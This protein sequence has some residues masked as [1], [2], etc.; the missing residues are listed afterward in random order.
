MNFWEAQRKARGRTTLYLF[1]FVLLTLAVAV[2]IEYAV[3]FLY[4]E[5]EAPSMSYMGPLFLIVTFV[6]A[7]FYYLTYRSQGGSFVAESLGGKRVSPTTANFE[8]KQLLNIVEEMAVASGQPLPPVYILESQE[9]NA[10]AAGMHPKNAVIAVTR[11]ALKL[12]NRDELQGVIGHEFGHIYNADMKISMRLAAMVMG[13][14]FVLYIGIRL[15][16]G[17]LLFGGRSNKQGGNTAALIALIFLIAGAITWFGGAI[18][19]SMVS[20]QREYLADAC[21]VQFTRNPDGIASAL[22]KIAKYQNV[23][24]MPRKGMAYAHLY[25]DNHSFWAS[26]FATHP[27]LSKRIAALEGRKYI[28]EEWLQKPEPSGSEH[29]S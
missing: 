8:E 28:P 6:V 24:D 18:L 29:Q 21:A 22:R 27:P 7:G 5:G 2:L 12:L 23:H 14:V 17:S 15:L 3:R 9:I 20:R 4:E 1:V 25:F 16:E 13:F 26:L 19:R 10:F 11:G